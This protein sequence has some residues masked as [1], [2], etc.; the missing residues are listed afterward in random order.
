MG[1][2]HIA[3]GISGTKKRVKGMERGSP[4]QPLAVSRQNEADVFK[5]VIR[6]EFQELH[7]YIDEEKAT[8]LESIEGK[9]AQLIT[10]IE[11]QAKQTSDALQRLKEMQ[12]SL[13]ALG[14]ESQLDFIRVSVLASEGS[15][16]QPGSPALSLLLIALSP[17]LGSGNP[18]QAQLGH[19]EKRDAGALCPARASRDGRDLPSARG[20]ALS[21]PRRGEPLPLHP[22]T[23]VCT[24]VTTQRSC[25]SVGLPPPILSF[26]CVFQ[27]YGSC[28]IR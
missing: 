10:S 28:Q 5:W 8:F 6:K 23:W 2:V 14:N 9:A 12:S 21:S 4:A 27:K 1:H 25:R 7:R 16:S 20:D 18:H 3:G 24:A 22:R 15:D 17:A 26:S 13:E 19:H 11:S